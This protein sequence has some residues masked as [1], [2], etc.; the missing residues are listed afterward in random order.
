MA[1]GDADLIYVITNSPFGLQVTRGAVYSTYAFEG[2]LTDRIDDDQ[3]RTR[4]AA[5]ELPP[6]PSWTATYRAE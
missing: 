6:R 4:V 5:G 2:P 1:T 3:W